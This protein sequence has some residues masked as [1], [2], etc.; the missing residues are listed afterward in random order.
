[1]FTDVKAGKIRKVCDNKS[2]GQ[3]ALFPLNKNFAPRAST[4]NSNGADIPF[5]ILGDLA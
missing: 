2:L 3:S 1:M 4:M 5:F